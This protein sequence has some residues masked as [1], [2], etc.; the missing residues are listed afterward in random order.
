MS[1][2]FATRAARRRAVAF[3]ALVSISLILMALSSSPLITEFQSAVGFA[4]RP[5]EGAIHNVADT[6]SGMVS[7]VGEIGAL[8]NDNASLRR[9]NDRLTA[10]NLRAT[11]IEHEN[12]Q[13]TALL[14]LRNS[15]AYQTAAAEVIARESSEARRSVTISKGSDAGIVLGDVVIAEG[16]ALVG[17]VTQVGPNFSIVVL[18]SD[19]SSTVIGQTDTSA[20]KGDVVGQLG[21]ALIMQ[22]IDSTEK[23]QPGEQVLTAGIQ[24]S[25]GVRSPYPKGLL[26]GVITDVKHDA[27]SVVQTAYLLPSIDLDKL[28]YVL[29]VL[30][31]VGGLPGAED[32]PIDCTQTGRGGALPGGE[33]PC[34]QPSASPKP[35]GSPRASSSPLLP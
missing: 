18:I 4:L 31:Y 22:N 25:G 14:Q 32:T 34:I 17:R 9:E 21:G 2:M 28:A 35:S 5:V 29:V 19:R 7:A 23:V 3:T 8:H 20:A 10:E 30:D 13:L 16:G 27:N 26:V 6:V 1:T 15:F 24:L 11:A 12:E 33:Q